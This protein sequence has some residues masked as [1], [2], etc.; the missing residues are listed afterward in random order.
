[1]AGHAGQQWCRRSRVA[2]T[3]HGYTFAARADGTVEGGGLKCTERRGAP[4]VRRRS[5][6]MHGG[7]AALARWDADMR[8]AECSWAG[9]ADVDVRHDVQPARAQVCAGSDHTKRLPDDRPLRVTARSPLSL[10]CSAA[11]PLLPFLS[12]SPFYLPF[13]PSSLA[14]P[15]QLALLSRPFAPL[16]LPPGRS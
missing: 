7:S 13:P 4:G 11:A 15:L 3:A 1:M 6:S 5:A 12:L 10:T 16:C 8:H 9:G 2:S 14:A